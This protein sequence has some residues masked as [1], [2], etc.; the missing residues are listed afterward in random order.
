MPDQ[1]IVTNLNK[2][3]WFTEDLVRESFHITTA[4]EEPLDKLYL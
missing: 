4:A 1:E 3:H 2:A